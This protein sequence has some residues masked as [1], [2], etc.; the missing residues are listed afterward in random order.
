MADR[1]FDL[2]PHYLEL[3]ER[4]KQKPST[5]EEIAGDMGIALSTLRKKLKTLNEHGFNIKRE[6]RGKKTFYSYTRPLDEIVEEASYTPPTA[7][8]SNPIEIPIQDPDDFGIAAANTIFAGGKTNKTLFRNFLRYADA[9]NLD[10]VLL[11]GNSIWMDLTRYSKY[12]PDRAENSEA[13]IDPNMIHYPPTV[14]KAGRDPKK[15]LE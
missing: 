15:L 12:K 8:F 5:R 6:M 13:V 4:L 11:T 7:P 3:L 14:V 9:K 2:K 1:P 10:G